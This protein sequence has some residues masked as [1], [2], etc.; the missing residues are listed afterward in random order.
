MKY[1]NLR[2]A[3]ALACSV[4]VGALN[5]QATADTRG[6]FAPR[7]GYDEA[8]FGGQT[9][10][11][12]TRA[13]KKTLHVSLAKL[14]VT[15]TGTMAAIKLPAT[16][17]ALIQHT[18]GIGE[19]AVGNEKFVPLEGEWLRLPLPAELSVGTDDDSLLLDLILVEER[20]GSGE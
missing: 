9:V 12:E 8:N 6:S 17:L 19:I 10:T 2:L 1:R 20:A 11:L 18:A 4:W 3:T 15:Q 16:G 14:R 5:A 7:D 13:G